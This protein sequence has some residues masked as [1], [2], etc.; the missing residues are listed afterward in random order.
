MCIY[1]YIMWKFTHQTASMCVLI[2]FLLLICLSIGIWLS[3]SC[4]VL[5]LPYWLSSNNRVD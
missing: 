3:V 5:L 4:I 2:G 1:I